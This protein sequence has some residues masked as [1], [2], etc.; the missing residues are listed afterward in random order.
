[1]QGFTALSESKHGV[2]L[3]MAFALLWTLTACDSKPN[4]YVEPPV[5]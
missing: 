2:R 5:L 3:A 1:M 4:E